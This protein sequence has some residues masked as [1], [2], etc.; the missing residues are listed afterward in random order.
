MDNIKDDGLAVKLMPSRQYLLEIDIKGIFF[1][2]K[3]GPKI[4]K[5]RNDIKENLM[6]GFMSNKVDHQILNFVCLYAKHY[7]YMN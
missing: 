6:L 5:N 3:K 2:S 1:I 4:D 7:I